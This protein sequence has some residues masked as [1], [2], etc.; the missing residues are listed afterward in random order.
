MNAYQL[1][2][3]VLN[4]PSES[5]YYWH[6]QFMLMKLSGLSQPSI[7]KQ[8]YKLAHNGV[9]QAELR[10]YAPG[11]TC[12]HYCLMGRL[13]S[14]ETAQQAV[15]AQLRSAIDVL[16]NDLRMNTRLSS[17]QYQS[18]ITEIKQMSAVARGKK[19]KESVY[20]RQY[21]KLRNMFTHL[22]DQQ[23]SNFTDE[24]I[25]KGSDRGV[26]TDKYLTLN[27]EQS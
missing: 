6:S 16:L 27:S 10:E 23:V 26:I 18:L 19:T 2:Q 13:N 22:T 8:L 11:K 9:I 14:Q 7:S 15:L 17:Q 3:D 1:L 20:D 25:T 5:G 21:T 4:S 12:R 24:L